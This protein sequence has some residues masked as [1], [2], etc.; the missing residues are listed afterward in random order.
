MSYI[1]AKALIIKKKENKSTIHHKHSKL[2]VLW[3]VFQEGL[4]SVKMSLNQTG[5][6]SCL[7]LVNKIEHGVKLP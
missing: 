1:L 4:W 3:K 5:I 6:D 7:K 2:Y